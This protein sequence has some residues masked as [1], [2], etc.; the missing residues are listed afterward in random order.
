MKEVEKE[1]GVVAATPFVYAQVMISSG[2]NVSGAILRGIDPQI[3]GKSHQHS[4]K[5]DPGQSCRFAA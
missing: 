3:G 4:G 1:P 2:K 5:H